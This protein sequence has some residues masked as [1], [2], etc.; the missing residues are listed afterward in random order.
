MLNRVVGAIAL[1]AIVGS[2]TFTF[3]QD[4][5]PAPAQEA[6]GPKFIVL[7]DAKDPVKMKDGG[8]S[9][10]YVIDATGY[11]ELRLAVGGHAT[12]RGK[13]GAAP[14]GIVRYVHKRSKAG[15]TDWRIVSTYNLEPPINANNL[16][17]NGECRIPLYGPHLSVVVYFSGIENESMNL[18]ATAYLMP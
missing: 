7:D 12:D 14:K 2:V 8:V 18:D 9:K 11:S 5:T 1:V 10:T 13:L 15:T 3:A 6:A 17:I 16:S 4:K